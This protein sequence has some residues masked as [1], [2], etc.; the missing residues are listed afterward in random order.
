[1]PATAPARG[2]GPGRTRAI[3]V[4]GLLLPGLLLPG[5]LLLA[6][7]APARGADQRT[8]TVAIDGVSGDLLDNVRAYLSIVELA[9]GKD[10][11]GDR[12][13]RAHRQA[14]EEI[15]RA[16]QAFG[17][18]RPTISA[19]LETT[20]S[21]WVAHYRIQPGPVVQI[22][23]VEIRV[24]GPGADDPALRQV[25][26]DS[27]LGRGQPLRHAEYTGTKRR[28]INT[29]VETGY[30]D[31]EYT[32]SALRVRPAAGEANIRLVL[33][34]GPAYHFG[35]VRVVQDILD[36][37]LIHGLV[38]VESGQRLTSA[39][40]LDLQFALSDSDYFQRVSV[41]VQRA[42]AEPMP[43]A[44]A[45]TAV[46]V[47]VVVQTA[48]RPRRKYSLGGGYGTDTGPR[49]TAGV[50]F[51]RLN[52]RGHRFRTDM[53][54]SQV[55][56][57]LSARYQIPI[58][59]VRSEAVSFTGSYQRA[60]LGDGT[61]RKYTVG[62]SRDREWLG[63]QGSLYT[64]YSV[65][66]FE[67]SHDTE[68]TRLLTPGI[69]LSRSR[70]D[71]PVH[72]R[73]GWSVYGDVHGAR[74][75]VLA[76]VSFAQVHGRLQSVLSLGSRLRLLGRAEAAADFSRGFA[77]LPASERFFAGGDRS[78]RGYAYQSLAP[79]N[80]DGDVVGGKYLATGSLEADLRVFGNWGV[81]AFYDVGN[82]SN[83]WPPQAKR[84]AG[85]GLRWFSPIG[86][87][88]LDYAVPLDDPDRAYRIHFSMGPDL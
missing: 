36:P 3:A 19:R 58:G 32:T 42:R 68:Q 33:A 27:P 65:E 28:L 9:K 39:R 83:D 23:G 46:R 86:T 45:D 56:T 16:L 18:Y 21:G 79:T 69:S 78:V 64:R 1:M 10:L 66:R 55:R 40:L 50:E 59:N 5:L 80:A 30:L 88:R 7:I 62:V 24:T 51:R 52:R 41:D 11:D 26:A 49:V 67:F 54:V 77:E 61:S 87:I 22:A 85:G 57:S 35:E 2:N 47:P 60:E 48:P 31:A 43:G 44:D 76:D 17:H 75:G 73:R 14:P 6:L 82:A 70:A 63:W 4:A 81:A 20:D 25:I 15:R 84:G 71:D 72:T 29:A 38:P 37:D 53:L 12:V 34:T 74:E 8:L 13:R